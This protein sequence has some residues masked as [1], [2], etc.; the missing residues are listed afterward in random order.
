MI[1]LTKKHSTKVNCTSSNNLLL[2]L[3]LYL[4]TPSYLNLKFIARLL[5][6]ESFPSF[7]N[8]K[9]FEC[10]VIHNKKQQSVN[11]VAIFIT[12]FGVIKYVYQLLAYSHS[13][14]V[15]SLLGVTNF[16]F[17]LGV[18]GIHC[19]YGVLKC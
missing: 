8:D 10:F 15:C 16:L 13:G 3:L 4:P 2:Y 14:L 7:L 17:V 11:F 19:A 1:I 6:Y 12:C 18:V 5:E 9:S